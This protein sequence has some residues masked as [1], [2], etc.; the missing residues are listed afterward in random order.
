MVA[1][2]RLTVVRVTVLSLNKT[3]Y[4]LLVPIQPRKIGNIPDMTE[5]LLNL[6]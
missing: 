6:M 1:S 2:S 4:P 5:K 3:L